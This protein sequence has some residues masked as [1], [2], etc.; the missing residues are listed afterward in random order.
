[1]EKK[2]A[3]NFIEDERLEREAKR[4][5]AEGLRITRNSQNS[6]VLQSWSHEVGQVQDEKG[7]RIKI[8]MSFEVMEHE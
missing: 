7:R 6:I 4:I 8:K 5:L 1:M 3:E 2:A